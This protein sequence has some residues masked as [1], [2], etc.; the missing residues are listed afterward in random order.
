MRVQPTD[1]CHPILSHVPFT[2]DGWLFELKHDGFRTLART[3]AVRQLR[4]EM[5]F[6][7]PAIVVSGDTGTR[8]DR[9]A[10][11]AG[12]TLLPKP[13]VG[14]TLCA[15]AL[16]ALQRVAMNDVC[17]GT[18]RTATYGFLRRAASPRSRCSVSGSWTSRTT[19]PVAAS[20]IFSSYHFLS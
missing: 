3:D 11:K 1:L 4:D 20:S 5:G 12:L 9:E 10:R 13:V 19:S 7:I 6:A 17:A 18:M 2:H 15:A 14:A 16:T 8:A